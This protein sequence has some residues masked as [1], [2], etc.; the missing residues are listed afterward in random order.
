MTLGREFVVLHT[1][2]SMYGKFSVHAWRLVWKFEQKTFYDWFIEGQTHFGMPRGAK[3]SLVL[4]K[5]NR[6]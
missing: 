3:I 2:P 4:N 6:L 5:P 1:L